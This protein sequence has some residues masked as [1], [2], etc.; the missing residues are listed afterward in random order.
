[1][2]EPKQYESNQDPA[3]V[4]KFNKLSSSW[5]DAEGPLKTLHQINPL[6]LSF[7]Q[8]QIEINNQA[9]L[10]IGCGG[11]ILTE[12]L[13]KLSPNVTGIDLAENSL[14]IAEKHASNLKTPPKYQ[15]I[16]AEQLAL[17][18]KAK[19]EIITCMELSENVPDPCELMA[20]IGTRAK[21]GGSVFVST[22]NRT[23]KS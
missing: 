1:M 19:Y 9:I 18:H 2:T 12:V 11:G 21:P 17:N 3:E 7:I 6:R 14:K 8:K 4:E 10:D 22:I 15:N 13:A 20:A 5:W 23:V 16:S